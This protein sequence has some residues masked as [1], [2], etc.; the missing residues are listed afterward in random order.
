MKSTSGDPAIKVAL[1]DG[2]VF[3]GHPD[4]DSARFVELGGSAAASC[5]SM[6]SFACRHGT[7]VA[8]VLAG[9]RG[10][11]APAICPGCTLL[12]RSVY[13]DASSNG[14]VMP[15]ASPIELAK[16][17]VEAVDAG[18]RF[19]NLSS[20]LFRPSSEERA[21]V[22]GALT[23]ASARGAI[24]VAA[25]GNQ[26]E[27]G[28][29][30]IT[31]HPGV[32]P[33]AAFG[34]DGR[35]STL[36][37][38]GRYV[39]ERG[40]GAPGEGIRSLGAPGEPATGAGT[41]VATPFVTGTLALLASLFPSATASQLRRALRQ[42][43]GS[44]RVTVVPPLLNADAAYEYLSGIFEQ[45]SGTMMGRSSYGP[46]SSQLRP[47]SGRGGIVSAAQV[48]PSQ[49]GGPDGGSSPEGGQ[50]GFGFVYAIGRVETS[51]PNQ[52]VEREFAQATGRE[53][54][55]GLTDREA[56]VSV[57][58][59]AG[60]RYLARQLC[61]VLSIEGMPT[62]ILQPTDPRDF[63]L[64]VE[65]LRPTPT[66]DDMDVLVGVRGPTAPPE[67]CNGLELPLVAVEQLY[68]FAREEL[69]SA[70]P[71][72]KGL[73]DERFE[74][75]SNEL[76]TRIMQVADNAGSADDHRA[77][78]YLAVRYPALYATA[79]DMQTRNM[80]LSAI[81]AR[82]SRLAMTERIIDV[83]FTF[84]HRETDVPERFFVR[85][86]VSSMFPFLVSKMAPYFE[87]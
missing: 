15:T 68:S 23:Y 27:L 38:L 84:T 74:S 83:I 77:L 11:G 34:L 51:F 63:D 24:I 36:S 85:V 39:G 17:I 5:S 31:R 26:G 10:S 3:A 57:L 69:I 58:T 78:N 14:A 9:R 8:G 1:I 41:S 16:A 28:G 32:V 60:N 79:S 44:R 4:F 43:L 66:N 67:M 52:S 80:S 18:A 61:W 62:Y 54:S 20:A 21:A 33:V 46:G 19:V 45:G 53:D 59:G 2:P 55:S 7:L 75:A 30:V 22:E 42:S 47:P 50:S 72:T 13:L 6:Q 86:N 48:V 25:A 40:V 65:S 12:V 35:P 70:I 71:K 87:R 49:A 37:N 73:S 56:M 64:L 76:L 81:E 29:S 82:P